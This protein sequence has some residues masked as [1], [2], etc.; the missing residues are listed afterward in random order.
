M[1]ETVT[2]SV[3]ELDRVQLLGLVVERRLSLRAAAE[4]MH[5]SERQARRLLR[6]FE[7]DGAAGLV[8][9]QRGRP[10]NRRLPEA[11]RE[12]ALGL[13]REKYHDFGPTLAHEKLTELHGIG[14]SVETLRKWLIE[15]G[16]WATRA[17]RRRQVHQPRARRECYGELIQIDGSEHRWFENRGPACTLLFGRPALN[18]HDAHRPLR[19]DEDLGEVFTWQETRKVTRSL[20]LHYKRVMYLL[21]K[22]EDARRAM[23]KRVDILETEEGEVRI[24]FEGVELPAQAFDKQGHV[25]QGAIVENKLLGAA[26]RHA[27][28]EQKKRDQEIL[29]RRLTKRERRLLEKKIAQAAPDPMSLIHEISGRTGAYASIRGDAS[30]S[31]TEDRIASSRASG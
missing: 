3:K 19:P 25:R 20:T 17:Q 14:I 24:R 4:R 30:A 11:V 7:A 12:R 6:R 29:A 9:A 21:D 18:P 31:E 8:S 26:L 10:S 23:G 22:T 28:E 5:L 1:A 2:M 27:Q 13:V 15:E 16:L